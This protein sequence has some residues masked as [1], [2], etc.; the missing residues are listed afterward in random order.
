VGNLLQ[1]DRNTISIA[2]NISGQTDVDWYTFALNYEQIQV[3]GGLSNGLKSWATMIDLDYGDGFRGDLSLWLFD[4]T[5][6]LIFAGR[7]SNVASDQPGA[8]QGSDADDLSRGS[9]G[10]LDPMIGTAQLPTGNPT[11]TFGGESGGTATPPDPTR[12]LRYY[13]AVSSNEQLPSQLNATFKSA[14]SN[15]LIRMEPIN[16]VDRVVEDHIGFTGYTSG[17]EDSPSHIAPMTAGPLVDIANSLSLST[18]VTPFTLSDVTLFVATSDSLQTVDAMRGGVETTIKATY[19]GTTNLSDLAMR[20]DGRLYSYRDL[21]NTANTAGQVSLVDAGT[22][23]LTTFGNDSIPDAPASTSNTETNLAPQQAGLQP[24]TT[25]ALARTGITAVTSG[26]IQYNGGALGT[27]NWS[28]S[29]GGNGIVSFIAAPGNPGTMTISPL[30]GSVNGS[31]GVMSVVWSAQVDASGVRIAT[32]TYNFTSSPSSLTTN[33]VDAMAW[34]QTGPAT[35]N[36]LYYSVNTGGASRLFRAD[37][38]NGSA[39]AVT[40]QPWGA[41]GNIQD[42]GS[43]LGVVTGMQFMNGTLYGVDTNGYF[44]SINRGT[45]VAT[46]IDLDPSTPGVADPLLVDGNGDPD[47]TGNPVRFGGLTLGPKNLYDGALKDS[48]F[49]IDSFGRLR[50]FSI[51]AG[52]PATATLLQVFDSDN[53]GIA[54]ATHID[55]TVG[56]ATGLAF[57]PLDINLWHPTARR[58]NDAGHGVNIAPDYTRDGSQRQTIFDEQGNYKD[59]TE[60]QGGVSMYFGLEQYAASN[61]PYL[62]YQSANGQYGVQNGAWQQDLTSNAEIANSYN[63]PGGAYGSLST[64]P[65]SLSGYQNTDKPTLYFN[66][67]LQTE[68]NTTGTADGGMVDSARAF[69]SKDGGVTWTVLA[70][71]NT[72]LSRPDETNA[73]L[74]TFAS[75]SSN[76][77]TNANQ[78]VQ[79]LFNSGSWRQARIDLGGYANEADLRLRFD[80]STAGEMDS[81]QRDANGNLINDING[82][83]GTTGDFVGVNASNRGLNNGYEGFYI[84]DIIVGFTERGEMV[85]GATAGQTD[86]FSAGTPAASPTVP[87]QSLQGNYQLEIR[88][89]TEYAGQ[90]D[91]IKSN[92]GIVQTVDTNADLIASNGALGDANQ[93]RQ[94]GQF[95]IEGNSVSNALTYGISIDAGVRDAGTNAPNQGVTASLPV[96]NTAR[97]V[98]GVVV[99]NNIVSSSGTAGILFSGDANKGNVPLAAVPYGRIVNNTIYGGT[100]AAGVGVAVTENAGPTLLNNL[101]ANLGVGVS[102]DASSTANTVI[103]TSAYWNTA[104]QVTGGSQSQQVTLGADPFVNAPAGNFYLNAGSQAIDSSLNTLA[105]RSGYVAVTSA[106]GIPQSPIIAP[107]RDRYGQLRSDDPTQAS[108]PGLGSNA[109][110]DRGAVDR[111]DTTQPSLALL[112]PLD[113]GPDDQDTLNSDAVRLELAA[114]RSV[115]QFELQLND[116]GVGIDTTTVSKAAFTLS[117]DG[118][119]LVEGTDYLF[120]Y[121]ENNNRVVFESAAVFPMGDYVLT[122]TSQASVPGVPGLLTDLANN[123][124]LP[125]KV[126]GSTSFTISLA[127]VPSVPA[128]VVATAGDATVDVSWDAAVANNSAIVRYEIEYR[129]FAGVLWTSIDAGLATSTTVPGLSNGTAY[130]FRVRAVNGVGN[131]DYSAESA[132]AMPLPLP[133]V[134]LAEDTGSSDSDGITNNPSVMVDELFAGATWE[135]SIDGGTTWTAGVDGTFT[136]PAGTYAA[137]A[138]AVRQ[139]LNGF[140]SSAV[141]NPIEWVVDETAPLA[142]TL[143]LGAGVAT[144]A[145][146]VEAMQV[147]GVVTVSGESGASIA[148]TFARGANSVTKTVTGTGAAQAVALLAEDLTTLGDGTVDVSA[149]A[150]DVAGNAGPAETTSFTLDTVAPIAPSLALGTGVVNGATA[151]EATQNSGVV[152]VS[153]DSGDSIAVTFTGTAGSVT[154]TVTGTGDVQPVVLLAGDLTTLGDGS[155]DVSAIATDLAGNASQTGTTSFTLDTV[156]PTTPSLALGTGVAAGATA[157]EATQDSGVVTV[158]G[159]SGASIAVTFTGTAGSVTKTVTG[160]GAAQAV[161]LLAG[162][163]TTLGN[164]TVNVS[165]IA[166]DL[167]GNDSQA[168]TT[169]FTLDTVAPTTPSLVLGTGVANGATSAEATQPTGVVTVSG[170]ATASIAVTFTGTVGSVTKTVTGTGAAQAVV[171]LAGD[172]TTLGNG[173]VN[174]SAIATDLA[175]NIGQAGT[176]S[177]TL[178]TAAPAMPSLALGAGVAAGATA[179]EATQNSGVVT[180]SGESGASIA[181][182]FTGTAGSVTKTVTGTGAAQAVVLLAGDLITLGNGTINVSAIATDLAGNPSQAGTTSFTLDTVAP[183]TPSLT[184]GIG[185]AAGATASEA[186]QN[187]G[188]VTV[189][190]EAGASIAVTF[191]GL[192]GS[193]TKTVTGTGAAQAVVLLAGDLTTLGNGSINVSAIAT[194]LAGNA[195]QAGTTSFTLDTVVPNTPSLAL[196]NGVTAGATAAE[197]T[198]NSGVVT[199]SGE[200]GASI[201]VTFTRGANSV[202]KTVTGTGAAQ[203]VVLLAGDLTTLGNGTINVS[204]IATDL[205]GN[206]SQAGATSFTLDTVAPTTP[207]LALGSG[208]ANGATAT[209][210]T[211]NSGVVTVSG[212]AGASIAVT[213]TRGSNSVTKTVTGTGAAQAVVLLAGDLTTLGNGTINVSAIA[214]DLAGNASQAGAISFTLDT[215]APNT[216]S[217]ALGIGVATGATAT[218]ATQNSGVV[219]VSGE[220]TASIAVTF[221]GTSGSVTKTVTGTGAAQAVV[222]LAGDLTTLGNGSITVSAIATD[223][224]GNASQAGTTSFTLDT[225]APT[226]PSLALGSGVANGATATEATQNSGVVTVSGEAGASIAVT[227]T[228]GANSVTKTV[229]GT[230]AAQAVVLLAGD[231]TT[232]GN[233]TINVSA[234]ATDLAGN[235]SQAATTSFTLDTVAP[236]TPSLALGTGVAAGATATEATQ[237]PGVVTVTGEAGASIAV[238]FTGTAGSVTKTVTGTGTAQAV[239]L[240]AGDLSTLGNGTVNISAIATDLAGNASLAGTTSFPLDTVAPNAP[241]LALGTGVAAGATAT[242]ASQNS[243]V[244]TVNGESGASIAITFTRGAN[245]VTKTVTGTGAAQ[246]VTLLAGDLTT[247]GNGT[248]NVSAIATDLAGNASQAGAI[249]FTLDT[250]APTTPSL[251]L[252]IGV[253]AGATATEATQNSGVVTVSGEA[254]ASIA[255]TFTGTA[256]SVTKTVTGIG[257]AQAVVLLAGDLTT[258]GNGTVSVSAIATDLAGNASLAGTT[259]FTLDTVAP[260]TPSLALGTGVAD[261]ATAAEITQDS[262]VVTVAG[263]SGASI[264]VTFTGT[265]GSVTKTFTGTGAAQAVVLPSGDLTTLGEG[266]VNVLAIATDIAGNAS[267]AGTTSFTLDTFAPNAPA[268]ELGTGVANGATATEATQNS[269]VVTVSGEAGASIAVTFSR[270]ANSVTKTVTGT[271]AA[272]AV[273]LLAG[274]LTTLGNGSINVSAIAT[275]LAGNASQAA[276]TSFTLDTV[277]PTTPSLALGI[278]VA[279]GATATEA[280]QNSGVVTV[281][282]ESGASITV[283]FSRGAN[284]VTKTVIGTGAAQ[285]VTLLAGDLTTLGNGTVNASAIATDLAGN[286]SQAGT[287]S[288]TLD[289]VVPTIVSFTATVADGTYVTAAAIPLVATLSEPV[290]AGGSIAV[291]LNTNAVVILTAAAQGNILTGTYAVSPGETTS[292]LNVVSYTIVSAITDLAGNPLTSTALPA[293]P[294]QLGTQKQIAINAV[295]TATANGFSTDAARIADKKIVVRVIP[296]TFSTPVRG[297]SLANFRLFYNNR[298]VALT[299]AKLT[300]S[301]ANYMLTLPVR[302]TNLKGLY[303]LRIMPNAR[304]VA[305]A[306]GAIMTQISQIFWGYGRSVGMTPTPRALAFSRR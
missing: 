132:P 289:T 190:G 246:A 123:V 183:A 194:D 276:T 127:D 75:V 87:A 185:V 53:D 150:T 21:I 300:G 281:S 221:T 242:E 284:S 213:F 102:V 215:V 283:T 126:D 120:R 260:N 235:A 303:T 56:G 282:G 41:M 232:L 224:A 51:T 113:N 112:N 170:E 139:L 205:A 130:V 54:D 65:F 14:A 96:L 95:L 115:T 110:K 184:L 44:F 226:T 175:G 244:V 137:G 167:A 187:S 117:R 288:F 219:T 86:F 13:V 70:T 6:K 200:S 252:G 155:I 50:A 89:G 165:A 227:F 135:S 198:Q 59:T 214:T 262:G 141:S 79:Q 274:D 195:S 239:V 279:A 106:I 138:V 209:E 228:R 290:Q 2:G 208:V 133:T 5:G 76:L 292:R 107:D 111:V 49:A 186:T 172:L 189:S 153:G 247:L 11:G 92:Y 216:P 58:G 7:D 164:G 169:S 178:D 156:A 9:F 17:T 202:T 250:V 191:T 270:G 60:A 85:T 22:G 72:L 160:T 26:T 306:N 125:N 3:I 297:V 211:Q 32:V 248:I 28:F 171:L 77:S 182:T 265:A 236:T 294:D 100:K 81:T 275:D 84:D 238:T 145:S 105:D 217:L 157:T 29:A 298:S 223:L 286:A 82:V 48:L 204:A 231:L 119:V 269:G 146:A 90:I 158:A 121:F 78:N 177:F 43:R 159:E 181:V 173:T 61:T 19:G 305:T 254:G 124:L 212:E 268:L 134:A 152:T 293:A 101:F 291:K 69:I 149:I 66:Y 20:S 97:L 272:Q 201:A 36:N 12:Q 280:T 71:N 230:G 249:S 103:G 67:W 251:A 30:S 271:G 261:G 192:A 188:V 147:S 207:S 193:V 74:P 104:S 263:E 278:G 10:K 83:A 57:S 131:G 24:A 25:F 128:N 93:P 98:P 63:L 109:F 220:A 176:T 287:T 39:A 206:A 302:A 162:D 296:I 257:A 31:T 37:P 118:V 196:G 258:L 4:S 94:Q 168:G 264:A 218:E 259:S 148:V 8:G 277:A 38:A 256:G 144:G 40:N 99:T 23:N 68:A 73:E 114:A 295:I 233:G 174:V 142:P 116:I 108:L 15:T 267:Q 46:L 55:T 266:T 285:A 122:A 240:L 299:G 203:A 253:A 179:T 42:A 80:F 304:I 143:A 27:G 16:S 163:L 225:V 243:G 52:P 301:G 151:A 229:T 88:R 166:T 136:L 154:K 34:E 62:N 210:A 180:V 222:L 129:T 18:H 237:N 33:D 64:N 91:P 241:S 245:S 255:V 197:A 161:V 45:G 140:T 234:I 1:T 35:Y 199:V 273:V 47:S